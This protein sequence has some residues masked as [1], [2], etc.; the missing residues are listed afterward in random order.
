MATYKQEIKQEAREKIWKHAVNTLTIE[1]E[2]SKILNHEYVRNLWEYSFNDILIPNGY[3]SD[4]DNRILN[5]WIDFS[6]SIYGTKK[7]QDLKVA[8]LSGEEPENDI[9]ILLRL[10]VRIENVWAVEKHSDSFNSAIHKAKEKFT[11]LKIFNGNIE[12][13][14]NIYQIKFDII[15]LDFTKS[16]LAS[17]KGKPLST[18]SSIIDNQALSDLGILVTNFCEP[19][20]SDETTKLLSSYFYNQKFT[21]GTVTDRKFSDGQP[22]MHY[23]DG[24]LAQGLYEPIELQEKISDNFFASYSAFCTHFISTYANLVSPVLRTLTNTSVRKVFYENLPTKS[25]NKLNQIQEVMKSFDI[26]LDI[27]DYLPG[28]GELITNSTDYPMWTFINSIIRGDSKLHKSWKEHFVN[29]KI[30]GVSRFDAI[31]IRDLML[32]LQLKDNFISS[33]FGN[34]IQA[35]QKIVDETKWAFCD[36]P[37]PFLW[38]E[39]AINQFGFPH[40]LQVKKHQRFQYRAQ[41]NTM[42]VDSF[43]FDKCRSLYDWLPMVDLYEKDLLVWERQMLARIGMDAIGG[44][45][46]DRIHRELYSGSNLIGLGERPWVDFVDGFPSRYVL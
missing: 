12:D 35:I 6:Y 20:H 45:M 19:E 43:V 22:V 27:D 16:L 11:N 28:E 29:T 31:R 41:R 39:L 23:T 13:L 2:D 1:R 4:V 40:H 25:N 46:N 17:G 24:P 42:F 5:N 7:P 10:G 30:N 15:Y 14:I 37:F 21:E 8:Y 3:V 9:D 18:I 36:L 26:H 38:I 32:H 33:R 44:K 34:A